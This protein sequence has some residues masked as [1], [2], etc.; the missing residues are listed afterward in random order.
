[1]RNIFAIIFLVSL[2]TLSSAQSKKD[3]VY[4]YT[5][6]HHLVERSLLRPAFLQRDSL[7]SYGD[8]RVAYQMNK[9]GF[10]KAQQA[11]NGVITSFQANGFN[12]LGKFLL[13]AKFA[14]NSIREDSLANSLRSGLEDLSPYYPYANKS[15]DYQRQNYQLNAS[16]GYELA[17][18]V[19]PFLQVDYHRHWSAGTVDPRLKSNRFTLKVKP[20]VTLNFPK[21]TL[22]LYGI[23]GRADENVSLLYKNMDFQSSNLYPDRMYYM[24]YGYGTTRQKDTTRVNFKYDNYKGVGI[25]YLK[26][27][28]SWHTKTE[29]EYQQYHNTNQNYSKKSVLYSGPLAIYDQSTIKFFVDAVK[30]NADQGQQLLIFDGEYNKGVDG[31][32]LTTGSLN[33]VNYKVSTLSLTGQYVKLWHRHHQLA[34]ELGFLVTYYTENR[35]DLLQ[36]IDFEVGQMRVEPSLRLYLQK[37]NT[38]LIQFAFAPYATIPTETTLEYSPLSINTF[39][40]NVVFWDYY[41]YKTQYLG[42]K[43]GV[44][45][46]DRFWGNNL[47]FYAKLDLRKSSGTIE[48]KDDI[49]PKFLSTGNRTN[50]EIGIRL[51]L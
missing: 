51:S 29:I 30:Y 1:M 27:L 35:K 37:S 26:K 23:I 2:F 17:H 10:R 18:S 8:V 50:M 13:G 9:G 39:I 34:K 5:I 15:G 12:R 42:A 4:S 46:K 41:Y 21:S 43:F 7:M 25:Q 11:Y 44:E 24:N 16:L 45:Y 22:G 6:D 40:Q 19:Q 3:S 47:A 36:A 31:N 49:K 48:L 38:K 14:F 20:G 32:K 33:K 28:Y